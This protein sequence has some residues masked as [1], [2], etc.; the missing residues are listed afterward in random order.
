MLELT[1]RP[2][3]D[4]LLG[5]FPLLPATGTKLSISLSAPEHGHT[6]RPISFGFYFGFSRRLPSKLEAIFGDEIS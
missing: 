6:V 2:V 3:T 4:C 1:H 5:F